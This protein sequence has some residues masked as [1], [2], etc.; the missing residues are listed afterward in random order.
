MS[1]Q[2]TQTMAIGLVLWVALALAAPWTAAGAAVSPT[3]EYPGGVDLDRSPGEDPG[4]INEVLNINT[5]IY[6]SSLGTALAA[7]ATL[8]GHILEVQASYAEGP[9]NVSKAVTIRGLTGSE[10]ITPTTDT[11]TSGD[12]RGWFLVTVPGVTFLDLNFD[13]EATGV[14]VRSIYQVIRITAA[15]PGCI[16]D[17]CTF[18]DVIGYPLA[19]YDGR[20]IASQ[21]D[22][23]I[24]DCVFSSVRRIGIHLFGTGMT[25]TVVSRITYTGKG[26]GDHIDYAVEF[27]GGA[28]GT[29][30][31][32]TVT[33]CTGVASD[34]STS[35]GVL[36]TDYFAPGTEAAINGNFLNGNTAA[37][38]NGYLATDASVTVAHDNDLSGNTYGV[39]NAAT[40]D[41]D[42][43]G[44]WWGSNIVGTVAAMAGAA[45]DYTPW[46]DVGTDTSGSA[47]FQGNF[48]TL[49]VDD[50]SPQVG[51]IG[52]IQ[53]GVNVA[54]V[55]TVLVGPGTYPETVT[56][57]KSVVVQGAGLA[58]T[59]ID[60]SGDPTAGDVVTISGITATITI[61]GFTIV[62]GPASSVGSNALHISGLGTGSAITITNNVLQC[63]QS[64]SGTAQDNFGL[65]AGYGSDGTLF[66]DHNT[67]YGGGDNPILIE[68][69]VGPCTLSYNT[70][71]RGPDD[72]ITG[73]KDAVFVM[74]Y[75]A[76]NI[77]AKF[78]FDNNTI[79]MG[80]G[81]IFDNAHRGTG[82]SVV[83]QY[84]GGAGPGG[85]TD[86]EI[87]NNQVMNL[88][89]FRRGIG[90]W[91]NSSGPGDI[92]AVIT[93][94]TISAAPAATGDHG[95]R[96]LGGIT[97]TTV[98]QNNVSGMSMGFQ[99]RSWNGFDPTG[100]LVTGNT[101]TGNTTGVSVDAGTGTV[102]Q[103]LIVGNGTGLANATIT[104]VP[105]TCNWWGH[106][107]GPDVPPGNPNPGI[108]GIVGSAIFAPWWTSPTGP[109]DGFGPNNVAAST[110]GL[111]ISNATPCVAIP[112]LFNRV[113]TVPA[114][115]ASVT[116]TLS[117]NLEL[118]STPGASILPGTWLSAYGSTFQVVDNGGGSYTVDQSILGLPCGVATGGQL[119][120]VA[121]KKTLAAVDGTGTITVTE[122]NVRDCGNPFTA[123]PGVPGA[124]ASIT[125][126]TAS[127]SAV[128]DLAAAQMLAGNDSDG[129][130]KINL[131]FHGAGD[132]RQL[133]RLAEGLR[134]LSR[135]RR[136]GRRSASAAGGLSA[137]R[138]GRAPTA[139][140]RLRPSTS[141]RPATTGTT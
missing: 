85:Y 74:N 116:F 67:V 57:P 128:A 44:N 108:N 104:A 23:T 134:I 120:T 102:T 66:F 36:V 61:D 50:D 138:L 64:A 126:D 80:G 89:S 8:P 101:F 26:A 21:A 42:A 119:F 9:V 93:G 125:I 46:L 31:N 38:A 84:T 12:A 129:T 29:V 132:R 1:C 25:T 109:C 52:R 98:G 33:N 123:L 124:P 117:S 54:T 55:T 72:N 86:V 10:V 43:S 87:T 136:R 137:G 78:E 15:A 65:I 118:C 135:V 133:P 106:V 68:R 2:R 79:D 76:S 32:S 14:P 19:S 112:V 56:I 141:R 73:G 90:L 70:I 94:N 71:Y 69:W 111:C 127:P 121:V 83:A 39:A 77:T 140:R 97:G 82:L 34:G 7:P 139:E 51:A 131:S 96:I 40:L 4:D 41:L 60:V 11:G 110:A 107:N 105:A 103:N 37:V 75:G 95:I 53:E 30:S 35:A 92:A 115:A 22:V 20:G 114:R 5:A 13:G 24:T 130:T 16:I 3:P 113:D 63:V 18:T 59:F 27:G 100:F 62:T 48:S 58:T 91:D 49:H 28:K 81:T 88:K 6:Y 17:N 45:V 99:S 122:V 47:G